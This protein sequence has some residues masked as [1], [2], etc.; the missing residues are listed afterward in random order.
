MSDRTLDQI[1]RPARV[2]TG[3]DDHV[4]RAR[5][6]AEYQEMPGLSLTLAQAARL[7]DIEQTRC[8]HL[9]DA[10]VADGALWTNGQRFL[11]SNLGRRT[12]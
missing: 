8:A 2:R 7:F 12:I 6:R 5:V 4:I 3:E 11:G 1:T 10:L 9:L